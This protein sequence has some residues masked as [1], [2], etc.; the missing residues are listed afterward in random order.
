MHPFHEIFQ[1]C[2]FLK[3]IIFI[4]NLF[5]F[6]YFFSRLSTFYYVKLRKTSNTI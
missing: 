2:E 6:W 5:L 4:E 1:V 3:K